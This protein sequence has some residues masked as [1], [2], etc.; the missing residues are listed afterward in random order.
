M[1]QILDASALKAA[2]VYAALLILM[3]PVLAGAV[4]ARRRSRRIG[5]GDGGD[6]DLARWIRI[7]GNFAETAPF[8]IAALSGLAVSGA[9]AAT[10]H[11][12]GAGFLLGRIAHAQGLASSGG[13]SAGRAAG[14]VL[15]LTALIA[16]AVIILW[17][18]L[19]A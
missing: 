5:L 16:A 14:M 9:G 7:H 2:L 8:G 6:K 1:V 15:T 4:I 13:V 18:C 11:I 10:V 19:A 17:R 3:L 12:I